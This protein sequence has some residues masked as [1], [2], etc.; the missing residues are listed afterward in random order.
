MDD[1]K[2]QRLK[3]TVTIMGILL[4]VGTILFVTL[5]FKRILDYTQQ[6]AKE[7]NGCAITSVSLPANQIDMMSLGDDN[8]IAVLLWDTEAKMEKIV[9]LDYCTGAKKAEVH[10]NK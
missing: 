4:I 10:L 5:L 3:K 7:K 2:L 6:A 1:K 9:V 8:Q